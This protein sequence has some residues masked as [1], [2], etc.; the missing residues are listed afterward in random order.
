MDQYGPEKLTVTDKAF[1]KA[2]FLQVSLFRQDDPLREL[3]R[4]IIPFEAN[5]SPPDLPHPQ[6][7]ANSRAVK[8]QIYDAFSEKSIAKV[9]FTALQR[10]AD[11]EYDVYQE[12]YSDTRGRFSFN[13][14]VRPGAIYRFSHANYE[15]RTFTDPNELYDLPKG[16]LGLTP[17]T[18]GKETTKVPIGKDPY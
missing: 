11:G 9:R 18:R 2:K 3:A 10:M 16:N 12:I 13:L 17:L 7:N 6:D 5:F 1:G 4:E 15:T 14:M 8:I